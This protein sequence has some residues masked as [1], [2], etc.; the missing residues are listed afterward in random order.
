MLT[1]A[2]RELLDTGVIDRTTTRTRGGQT[3]TVFHLADTTNRKRRIEDASKRKRLLY[4]RHQSWARGTRR[5]PRGLVGPGGET[6]VANAFRTAAHV[7]Y[8]VERIAPGEVRQ[9]LGAEVLGGPL[10]NAAHLLLIDDA[11]RTEGTIV[12]PV[13]VKNLRTWIFPGAR[14]LH[15]LLYKSARL[16]QDHP[17]V[18]I[19]PL[20]TCR[21]Y[22]YDTIRMGK[23]LG[24]YVIGFERQ[25]VLP[26]VE[27]DRDHFQEVRAE[28]GYL[29]L[30]TDMEAPE[31]LVTQL[32]TLPKYAQGNAERW[33]AVGSKML[34]Y[35]ERLKRR[36]NDANRRATMDELRDA[37][38]AETGWDVEW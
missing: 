27:L 8:R 12:I 31:R 29:D 30:S 19:L 32:E 36:L 2:K 6:V 21:R 13:E 20:L 1:I 24:F 4:A 22:A 33:K 10:D 16:A 3:A 15:H 9:L 26:H 38:L 23:D 17:D 37:V 28:L 7:G 35:Y 18:E 11:G 5:V 14:E 34:S 25:F